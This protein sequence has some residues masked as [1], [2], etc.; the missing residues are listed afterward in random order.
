MGYVWNAGEDSNFPR[1]LD[2]SANA[3]IIREWMQ[4]GWTGTIYPDAYWSDG[5]R[6]GDFIHAK[7]GTNSSAVC[8]APLNTPFPIPIYD[9]VPDCPTEVP[10]AKPTCPHQGSSY[11]YHIVGIATVK[12]TDCDQGGGEISLELINMVLGEGMPSVGGETGY[13]EEHSCASHTQAV[14][15][16]E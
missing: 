11:V 5:A 14:T 12:V 13:G 4:N 9:T 3:N 7:P 8:A 16:W 10:T 6:D 15:L 2:Q 1:A